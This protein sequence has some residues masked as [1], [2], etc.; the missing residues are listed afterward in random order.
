MNLLIEINVRNSVYHFIR[1][2]YR[3]EIDKISSAGENKVIKNLFSVRK[4]LVILCLPM[5]KIEIRFVAVDVDAKFR[6]L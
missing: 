4:L 3:E 1:C 5:V 2:N 6:K